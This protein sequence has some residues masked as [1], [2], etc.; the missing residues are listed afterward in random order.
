MSCSPAV[1]MWAAEVPHLQAHS[2]GLILLVGLGGS[3]LLALMA[4]FRG[5]LPAAA[6]AAR[7]NS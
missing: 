1:Q 3:L 2:G 7:E 5:R 6:W 4:K